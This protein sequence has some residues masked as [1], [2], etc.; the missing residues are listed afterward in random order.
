MI[1]NIINLLVEN[2]LTL[3]FIGMCIYYFVKRKN[4]EAYTILFFSYFFI[5]LLRTTIFKNFIEGKSLV[6]V[7]VY[8]IEGGAFIAACLLYL[9]R[10]RERKKLAIEKE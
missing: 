2:I 9:K 10:S 1:R 6:I 5:D 8:F 3:Y 4:R 7:G